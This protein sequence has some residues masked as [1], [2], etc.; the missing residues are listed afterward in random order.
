MPARIYSF[1]RRGRTPRWHCVHVVTRLDLGG[2]QLATLSE[3]TRGEFITG[4][5]WLVYGPGGELDRDVAATAGI[6]RRPIYDLVRSISPMRDARATVALGRIIRELQRQHPYDFVLVH[7]H[8]SKAGI[9]GRVAAF[10][11]GAD[12]IV[13][14][15]HGF[16]HS[17]HGGGLG[18]RAL[19]LTEKVAGW[20]TDGFTAD[21][22]ANREQGRAEGLF[23]RKPVEVVHCGID[24]EHFA[25]PAKEPEA[26]RAEL[27]IPPG[28]A[29]VLNVSCL[30]PQKDPLAFVEVARRVLS[31]RPHTTF[32]LAGDGELR[33]RIEAAAAK[34]KLGERFKLLGW[35]RDVRELM[36]ASDLLL[37]TSRWEGLPQTLGQAMA[38]GLPVVATAVDGTPEAVLDG[39]TGLLYEPGDVDGMAAGALMLLG[40][41]VRRAR[42]GR[43]ARRHAAKFSQE[44]ALADLDALYDKL[45]GAVVRNPARHLGRPAANWLRRVLA[46][47]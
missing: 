18:R 5:R 32:L 31:E 13:H 14:S 16:G 24:L 35:R 43:T 38:V 4:E 8:S 23:G 42:M 9:L 45:A 22:A 47:R 15:V 30:K 37:L 40:D 28:D 6:T 25:R 46:V 1:P 36:H 10:V 27:G 39:E 11:V 3:L 33:R 2:A 29:V 41:A 21:S 12:V 26:V 44:R 20:M 7:T 19:W 17:H 34:H